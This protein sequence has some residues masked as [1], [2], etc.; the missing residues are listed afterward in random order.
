MRCDS[1]PHENLKKA[2]ERIALAR[3]KGADLVV[4]PELFSTHY[5]CREGGKHG[6]PQ[7]KAAEKAI[8]YAKEKLSVA[9]DGEEIKGLATAA[10]D[11]K[12]VLVGGS[13]FEKAG[14]QYF[15]TSV[16]FGPDGKIIGLYRKVHI[17]HDPGFWEQHYFSPGNTDIPVYATPVGK[18][19]VQICYD[20]WSPRQPAWPR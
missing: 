4:L 2:I 1:N 16:V 6:G 9:I 12:V 17:P 20:Q 10:R 8:A 14:D 13:V 5:F 3:T 18:V 7:A 19:A 11:N 15:N